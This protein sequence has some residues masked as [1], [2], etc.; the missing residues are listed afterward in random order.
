MH[1]QIACPHI[2]KDICKFDHFAHQK[3]TEYI[4]CDI[5]CV[6]YWFEVNV[7]KLVIISV[8]TNIECHE[9]KIKEGLKQD[10]SGILEKAVP[11]TLFTICRY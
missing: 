1:G 6:Q 8:I 2:E 11:A 10:H 3:N 4:D 9:E 5:T 7:S